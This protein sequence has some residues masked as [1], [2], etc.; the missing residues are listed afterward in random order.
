MEKKYMKK[1]KVLLVLLIT[2]IFLAV[3]APNAQAVIELTYASINPPAHGY[4]VADRA[5]FEKIEKD[6]KG[7]LKIKPYWSGTLMSSKE[8]T[9]ELAKGVAD[10][11]FIAPI[12]EKAG[13]DLVKGT[14]GFYVGCTPQNAIKIFWMIFNKFPEV[15]KEYSS[16]KILGLN[17][18]TP[19]DLQTTKK[20]VTSLADMKG[21]RIKTS[22]DLVTT[23]RDLGAE[24]VVMPMQETY[25]SLQKGLLTAVMAP[26]E[27]Y[28]SLKFAEVIKYHTTNFQVA[29]GVYGSRAINLDSWKKLPSNIQKIF[30]N[31]KE[32]WSLENFKQSSG[33]EDA[34]KEL[35]VKAGVKFVQMNKKDVEKYEEIYSAEQLKIAQDLDKKGLPGTKIFNETRRLVKL[36]NK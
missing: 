4:S 7:E 10:M 5:F 33:I 29:R 28:K 26:Y 21:L 17:A 20:P 3:Q 11:G 8:G 1:S 9:G 32:W 14:M 22:A 23:F 13:V 18:S 25:E 16:V 34:G 36:Y 24:G 19:M 2:F 12:Y 6:T 27:T 15:Q 30:E 35:A 31:S